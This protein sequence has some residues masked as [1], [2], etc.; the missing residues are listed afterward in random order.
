MG[1]MIAGL[2]IWMVM[3]GRYSWRP[4]AWIAT[5]FL[6][7]LAVMALVD[8]WGYGVWTFPPWT[9]F[10][11]QILE[12]RVNDWG[13]S[14]WWAYFQRFLHQKPYPVGWLIFAGLG[15]AITRLRR[16]PLTWAIVPFILGHCLVGH[17]EERFIFPVYYLLP[18]VLTL[19][20]PDF[21]HGRFASENPRAWRFSR[22]LTFLLR[23]TL[24]VAIPVLLLETLLPL[25]R[26]IPVIER[27]LERSGV[28]L[29]LLYDGKRPAL[30]LLDTPFYQPS[31]YRMVELNS[32]D[33]LS[34]QLSQLSTGQSAYWMR[35]YRAN[36]T[37]KT[38]P[39]MCQL[40][41]RSHNNFPVPASMIESDFGRKYLGNTV[42]TEAW[43]CSAQR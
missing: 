37:V 3:I 40:L 15:L 8:R 33:E 11:V 36:E 9:Y 19:G 34:A 35:H 7:T 39:G 24:I 21:L 25:R 29:N 10:R 28:E 1:F 22:P 12:D 20:L 27:V 41:S 38:P 18:A 42:W 23:L 2:G 6:L 14:P 30:F 31:Q 13:R 17:K 26:N 5:G 4:L 16:H 32:Q 43:H